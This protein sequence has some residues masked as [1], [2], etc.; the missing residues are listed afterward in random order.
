MLLQ[1]H[2]N[3]DQFALFDAKSGDL[4]FYSKTKNPE[5]AGKHMDGT[6]AEVDGKLLSFFR[7]DGMLYLRV[8]EQE[9]PI[10]DDTSSNFQ[11]KGDLHVFEL[12]DT[13]KLL[14]SMSY[15]SPELLVSPE[16]DPT[17]FA[18]YEDFDFLYFVHN[19]LSDSGRRHR[20]FQ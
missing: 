7:Q 3:F 8:D 12:V 2:D 18:E 6:Y 10:S 20:I 19:A 15:R 5:L 16:L 1:S 17:P 4:S 14:F 9:L 11:K 13:R